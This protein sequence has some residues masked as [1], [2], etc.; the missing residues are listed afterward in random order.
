VL[1]PSR[2]W[3][4]HALDEVGLERELTSEIRFMGGAPAEAP[5]LHA[6]LPAAATAM[7]KGLDGGRLVEIGV[8]C[9]ACHNGARAHASEPSVLPSFEPRSSLVGVTPPKG[10]TGT[11]AQWINRI[12]AKC[13]TVLF[14]QYPWTWE[15]AERRA[16][17]PGGSSTNSGEGRD[18]QLGGCSTEMACTHCHDPHTADPPAKLAAQ[19]TPAGNSLCTG[20]HAQM[21][22]P[23][24]IELHTHHAEG[25]AGTAC[26]ACHMAKKNMGLDYGLVRYHRIGS[27]TEPRRVTLDRP[28]E[29]ALCHADKSVEDLVS[30]MEQWWHKH[31][32]RAPLRALYGDDLGVNAI[33]ATLERG[34]PHEQAVAIATLGDAHDVSAVAALVPMLSHEYPLLRYY[35][36]RALQKITGDPVAI[37]VGAPA[38]DVTRAAQAW[39]TARGGRP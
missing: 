11:R 4:A 32:D 14:T 34:K 21:A 13:H 23:K 33:R 27:P 10:Q 26:I 36:Q 15:G 24:G 3:P 12:C 5:G 22:T 31:Y 8:G 9:E 30:T 39:L 1:P 38:A 18:F 25:S 37:D 16:Q 7:R 2:T 35:A 6:A 20:C 17:H 19:A 28:L 29:C